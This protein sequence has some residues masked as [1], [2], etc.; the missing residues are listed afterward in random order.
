MHCGG[1]HSSDRDRVSIAVASA[2]RFGEHIAAPPSTA[3][4]IG[5]TVIDGAIPIDSPTVFHGMRATIGDTPQ[6]TGSCHAVSDYATMKWPLRD[7]GAA[8]RRRRRLGVR[9]QRR[10]LRRRDATSSIP[11]GRPR[12]RPASR[13]ASAPTSCSPP[14]RTASRSTSAR[15][16]PTSSPARTQCGQIF[17]GQTARAT[18]AQTGY[19]PRPAWPR[20]TAASAPTPAPPRL[21][22]VFWYFNI[23]ERPTCGAHLR[24]RR[25]DTPLASAAQRACQRDPPPL[26]QLHARFL[27]GVEAVQV[28]ASAMLHV[29]DDVGLAVQPGR[30]A[31]QRREPVLLKQQRRASAPSRSSATAW[32]RR[33]SAGRRRASSR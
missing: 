16:A 32:C 2:C 23:L 7:A 31:D 1:H 24:R 4:P 33:R 8:E 28:Q 10:L 5:A 27:V 14:A 15:P 11:T 6:V 25:P 22:V 19:E 30:P 26:L 3:A 17:V 29:L 20:S 18:L 9:H 12:R 21:D 13:C